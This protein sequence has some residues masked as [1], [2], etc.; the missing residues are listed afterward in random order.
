TM[1]KKSAKIIETKKMR[2]EAGLIIIEHVGIDPL[3][4]LPEELEGIE[5]KRV[6]PYAEHVLA[7]I[8]MITLLAVMARANE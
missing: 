7:D 5:D 1:G 3:I 6:E 4:A 8:V 2:G